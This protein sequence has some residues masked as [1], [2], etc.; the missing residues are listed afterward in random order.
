MNPKGGNQTL[1]ESVDQVVT[2]FLVPPIRPEER[3][4]TNQQQQLLQAANA[5]HM[6][7]MVALEAMQNHA[8]VRIILNRNLQS[9]CC[10][11]RIS[12]ICLA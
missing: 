4:I 7:A 1:A 5:Q 12:T 8:K 9:V 11:E 10:E 6:A 3:F 2:N